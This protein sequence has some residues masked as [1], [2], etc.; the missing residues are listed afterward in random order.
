MGTA[1]EPVVKPSKEDFTKITFWPD[2]SKF[3]MVELD[4]GIYKLMERRAY[5]VAASTRGVKVFLN[6]KKLPVSCA[7][8]PLPL[9]EVLY[10]WMHQKSC[11]LR[12]AFFMF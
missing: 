9:H 3:K 11:E 4:E 12:D 6:G 5:D 2:L 1:S 7:F 10:L 8:Q